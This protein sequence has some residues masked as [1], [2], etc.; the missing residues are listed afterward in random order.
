[1]REVVEGEECRREHQLFQR[2]VLE[3]VDGVTVRKLQEVQSVQSVSPGSRTLFRQETQLSDVT[4]STLVTRV[5]NGGV[6]ERG[7]WGFVSGVVLKPLTGV[8]PILVSVLLMD[9]TTRRN[10]LYDLREG[11]GAKTRVLVCLCLVG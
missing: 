3:K 7:S 4:V 6:R 8:L 1:M 2:S 5:E 10:V 11:L 9:R